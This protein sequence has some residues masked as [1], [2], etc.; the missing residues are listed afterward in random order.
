MAGLNGKTKPDMRSYLAK[1][2][3]AEF[4]GRTTFLSRV[5][6][7]DKGLMSYGDILARIEKDANYLRNCQSLGGQMTG[8]LL[9]HGLSYI[10][11]IFSLYTLNASIVFL[12]P[13]STVSELDKL[14]HVV[15]LNYIITDMAGISLLEKS[16][17]DI[18][19]LPYSNIYFA[20]KKLPFLNAAS[21]TKPKLIIFTSGSTGTP[22]AVILNEFTLSANV[23][24]V[25]E[26]LNLEEDD[27]TIIYTP[28]GYVYAINQTLCHLQR[29]AMQF[30]YDN[31]L[32]YPNHLLKFYSENK[33]TGMATNPTGLRYFTDPKLCDNIQLPS[34]RYVMTGGQPLTNNLYFKI[35]DM[36]P[37]ATIINTYGC[38]E[39]SARVCCWVC[40]SEKN[41]VQPEPF[42]VGHA[43]T[44]TRIKI[45]DK[46]GKEVEDGESG[47]VL[48]KAATVMEGYLNN[49]IIDTH[50]IDNGWF[51]TGDLGIFNNR[52]G[53]RLIG[54][55]DDIILSGHNKISPVEV[56]TVLERIEGVKEAAVTHLS[57]DMFD[58]RIVALIVPAEFKNAGRIEKDCI[59]MCIESLSNFKRPA[60]YLFVER[61]PKNLYGKINRKA[62]PSLIN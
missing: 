51:N 27:S 21:F 1:S 19:P 32:L 38:T 5:I 22:N 49:G 60:K 39:T 37:N 20:K 14:I 16:N 45:V 28:S 9:P 46:D 2:I 36:F 33:I 11:S 43:V 10:A 56:E 62:L 61:I 35:L 34:L 15:K 12:N 18:S 8:I 4:L 57:D 40:P 26:Y 59:K 29:L 50:K 55:S 7:Y 58:T 44:G 54:R 6:L 41:A 47:H 42:P 48:V 13:K 25:N 52:D 3:F 30:S 23:L 24:A 53:L 17:W 31:G